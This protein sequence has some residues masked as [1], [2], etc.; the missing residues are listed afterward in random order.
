M[1][2]AGKEGLAL[3]EAAENASTSPGAQVFKRVFD[4]AGPSLVLL[5]E[6]VAYVRQLSG[7]RFEAHR[8]ALQPHFAYGA[9]NRADYARAHAMHIA[10]HQDE[11]VAG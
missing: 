5:D 1:R 9:L 4:M 10:N 6:L 3:V 11:I 2:L 7:S 8:G